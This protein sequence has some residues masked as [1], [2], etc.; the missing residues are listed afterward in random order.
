MRKF[1]S[2]FMLLAM[3][4]SIGPV[5]SSQSPPEPLGYWVTHTAYKVAKTFQDPPLFWH[6]GAWFS[7]MNCYNQHYLGP[8]GDSATCTYPNCGDHCC[9]STW[10]W[11]GDYHAV[12][13]LPHCWLYS[14]ACITGKISARWEP[15]NYQATCYMN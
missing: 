3:L 8:G 15:N 5:T 6:F 10:D 7:G 1:I 11:W 12:L 14:T 13:L 9:I 4:L 2:M